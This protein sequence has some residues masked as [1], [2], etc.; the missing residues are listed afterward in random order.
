MNETGHGVMLLLG[1]ALAL[2]FTAWR[3]R[4]QRNYAP[5]L[6]TAAGSAFLLLSHWVGD[7]LPATL[8][9]FASLLGA[10]YFERATLRAGTTRVTA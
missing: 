7:W 1:V 6:L 5:L 10:T 8:L 3:A 2:S 9:G 4:K